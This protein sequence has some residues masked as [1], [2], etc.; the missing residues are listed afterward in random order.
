MVSVYA[1]KNDINH[2]IYVGISNNV[3]RRII[4]HNAGKNR[5]TKAFRPWTVFYTEDYP[6]Y[7]IARVKEKYL[8]STTGKRFLRRYLLDITAT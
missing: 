6:D 5:Y 2:E 4:E 8:K 3:S 7:S 1:L